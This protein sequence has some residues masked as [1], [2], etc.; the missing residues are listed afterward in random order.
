MQRLT[1]SDGH[2]LDTNSGYAPTAIDVERDNHNT[3]GSSQLFL[4]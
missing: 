4:V 1:R 2:P 3:G